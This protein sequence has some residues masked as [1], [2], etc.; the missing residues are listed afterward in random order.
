MYKPLL[1]RLCFSIMI[2]TA[3]FLG[4]R[5]FIFQTDPKHFSEQ[6]EEN[7]IPLQDRMDLAM[8]YEFEITKEVATN[9]VPRERLIAAKA[10]ALQSL[11]HPKYG[12][13]TQ[14]AIPGI[15]WTERGPNNIGGRTRSLLVDPNDPTKKTVWAGSVGGG[16][17][18][19]TDITVTNPAWAPVNDFFSNIAVTTITYN[20]SV[21]T[22]MYFGTGEGYFNADAM[23]GLG[24]WKSTDAGATWNQLASTNNANFYY[25]NRMIVHPSGDLYATTR[26]GLFRS[27]DGG[28]TFNR[29]LGASAPGGSVTDNF[30]DVELAADNSIWAGSLGADGGVYRSTTG[31]A[32][33]WTLLNTGANGF[34]SNGFWR[35]D[36][37]CAPSS[38]ATCYAYLEGPAGLLNLYKTTNTGATWTTCAKPA[39][40]DGGIP[41]ADFTRSQAWYDM[42][43]A[44]DPNN[45]NNVFVGG[46][47]LFKTT[48]GGT[49]WA[50]VAHWYGGFGFQYVHADQH[51]VLYEPGNSNVI[52]FGNDGGVW[53]STNATAAMPAIATKDNSYDVTQYYACAVHPTAYSNYFLAGAQDNGTHKF[54]NPGINAVTSPTGG[55]GCYCHIDQN[56]P[57]YQWTSYVYNNYYRSTDGG[58]TWTSVSFGNSGSFVN[59]TDYD[60]ASNIFYAA[61]SAGN[62]MRWTDP[63]TGATTATVNVTGFGGANV[64][65]ISVSQNTPNRVFFGLSNGSVVR[66]DNANSVA[67]PAAGVVVG[68]P[69]AN[70]SVSC[71]AIENGNDNHILVTYSNYGINSVWESTNALAGAPTFTSVEGNLPDMPVRW[72]LFSPLNNAQA[73]LG[74]EVGAWS[75]D[76]LNG[77]ATNWGASSSGL[78][79]T[80]VDMLQTRTSDNLVAAATH[81]RGLFTS[82][83]FMTPYPDFTATP[84]ITYTNKSIQFSDGSYKSTS[85]NWDFGDAVTSALKNPMHSYTAP[86]L[87]TVTLVINGNG[88][89]TKTRVSYV[90]VL[91]DRATPYLVVNGDG[92]SFDVSPLDFGAENISGT[93]WERG[94]SGVANKN[95]TVSG[96][97]AWVTGLAAANYTDNTNSNLYCPSFNMSANGV[98]IL[99]FYGKW[100]AE[101][102][103]D[104]FRVEYSLDKGSNWTILGAYGPPQWYNFD[105]LAGGSAFPTGEPFFCSDTGSTYY[106]HLMDI[107]ALKGNPMVAFRFVFLSDG[108]VTK[109]GVAIDNFEIQG[110]PNTSPLPVEL[111]SFIGEAKK[112]YNLLSWTTAS[113]VNNSGFEIQR[114]DNGKDFSKINFIPGA[115]NSTSLKEYSF[116]DSDIGNRVLYYRL[117]QID[118]DGAFKY[119]EVVAISN[120]NKLSLAIQSLYPNPFGKEIGILLNRP[121]EESVTIKIFDAEG[122][123]VFNEMYPPFRNNIFINTESFSA[124]VYF[125][126]LETGESKLVKRITKSE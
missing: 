7:G 22:T 68:T 70:N 28:T 5:S 49:S 21:P 33:S 82:D 67:S 92:G 53:R 63:Q 20:P 101:Q 115:G 123:L 76:L 6:Q 64:R 108:S 126:S 18:K 25:V 120:K 91:P 73:I 72:A 30:S 102:A 114:S 110:P 3:I 119:S 34:P 47:D 107:S 9:T 4:C 27:Q 59:P 103:Y 31:N 38:A 23:R 80:R 121:L 16:I 54:V 84:L 85:W 19:T 87:Y 122:K 109:A 118:I 100:R 14:A 83:V 105:N 71:I 56:Q 35:V 57:Q 17:W 86:G 65:H 10:S 124:G 74:T 52:Y 104:G 69:V 61:I 29:V 66:V 79:N 39:D 15:A 45:A 77:G 117:K 11:Q 32:G 48:N 78:A 1:I 36:I 51:I 95:G 90:Q 44:V 46:V 13:S 43:M 2:V 24:I 41:A 42:S 60:D 113:E 112:D 12:N 125:I 58:N 111:L 8:S 116:K 94:N 62:Y 98:Y 99:S 88:A 81:G 37:A 55:D 89:Y 93:P 40:A 75:T 50:Q 96:S 106:K 97:S 26:N